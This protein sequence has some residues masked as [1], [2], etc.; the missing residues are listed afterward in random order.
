M[1][2]LHSIFFEPKLPERSDF[3]SVVTTFSLGTFSTLL[4]RARY[5]RTT[6]D[7]LLN[8]ECFFLVYLHP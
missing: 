6:H 3:E 2:F 1:K 5:Y 4:P 8:F 7:T